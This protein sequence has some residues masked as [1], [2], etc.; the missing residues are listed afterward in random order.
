[1]LQVCALSFHGLPQIIFILFKQVIPILGTQFNIY[2]PVIIVV[3]CV[4]TLWYSR[5]LGLL[6]FEHED[7]GSYN[8]SAGYE[9]LA[10][11]RRTVEREMRRSYLKGMW[12]DSEHSNFEIP[13]LNDS[14]DNSNAHEDV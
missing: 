10:E 6:G 2:A 11:G 1:M 5:I 9:R 7:L 4:F 13:E 3:L 8:N 14:L 12:D